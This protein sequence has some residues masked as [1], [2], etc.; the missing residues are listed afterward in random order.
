MTSP[1]NLKK[2]VETERVSTGRSRCCYSLSLSRARQ[3]GGV[4]AYPQPLRYVRGA[5]VCSIGYPK[6][7]CAS[8]ANQSMRALGKRIRLQDGLDSF[9]EAVSTE[10]MARFFGL[11]FEAVYELPG[12]DLKKLVS[13]TCF[14]PLFECFDLLSQPQAFSMGGHSIRLRKQYELMDS[15]NLPYRHHDAL[16]NFRI[17]YRQLCSPKNATSKGCVRGDGLKHL[18]VNHDRLPLSRFYS[19]LTY[20]V[21]ETRRK[22]THKPCNN[23]PVAIRRQ[24]CLGGRVCGSKNAVLSADSRVRLKSPTPLRRRIGEEH[25]VISTH[26]LHVLM[27]PSA[28]FIPPS[29]SCHRPRLPLPR[30]ALLMQPVASFFEVA[31]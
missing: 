28:Q 17:R 26:L 16:T 19:Q 1:P 31:P 29:L 12:I 21:E 7:N 13:P 18:K 3:K 8:I 30:A 24:F 27:A 6:M 15:I 2:P 14:F 20:Q 5:F 23:R 25:L 4:N 22:T 10:V 11:T 9:I